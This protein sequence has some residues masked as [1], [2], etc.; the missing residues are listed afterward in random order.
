MSSNLGW[1]PALTNQYN[2][3]WWDNGSSAGITSAIN[4]GAFIVQ[5]RDHGWTG[6]WGEPVYGL[7]DLDNLNNTMYTYVYSINCQT[8]EYDYPSEVFARSSIVS[9]MVP[10]VLWRQTRILIHLSMILMSGVRMMVCLRILIRVIRS[11][12]CPGMITCDRARR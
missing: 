5:H 8:G 2:S 3:T 6:G 10:W 12:I 9:P 7:G 4:S 1:L 11:L